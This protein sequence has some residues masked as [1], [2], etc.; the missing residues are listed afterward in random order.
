[1]GTHVEGNHVHWWLV[2]T[3]AGELVHAICKLC[4]AERDYKTG[5]TG[6]GYNLHPNKRTRVP[7]VVL[8]GTLPK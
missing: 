2:D 5:Y 8:P 6:K 3:P 7:V 1:M 4:G